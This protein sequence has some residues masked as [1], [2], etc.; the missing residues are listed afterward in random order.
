MTLQNDESK[1]FSSPKIISVSKLE[2]ENPPEIYSMK[3]QKYILWLEKNGYLLS[4][5]FEINF[6]NK[7]YSVYSISPKDNKEIK[8]ESRT[9][10][11]QRESIGYFNESEMKNNFGSRN[12]LKNLKEDNSKTTSQQ[13][14]NNYI[15]SLSLLKNKKRE[16]VYRYTIVT[17]N[18]F[19]FKKLNSK[20]KN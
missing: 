5:I 6:S 9:G 14:S 12:E 10:F 13:K 2:L 11:Y 15:D 4:K 19:L 3:F 20:V 17:L 1:N 16:N 7:V 8:K 18:Y